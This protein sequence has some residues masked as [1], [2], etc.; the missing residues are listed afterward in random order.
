MHLTPTAHA[1]QSV[2]SREYDN[3]YDEDPDGR[4]P[5]TE[6]KRT[7]LPVRYV[8][9]V[10]LD[11]GSPAASPASG[12]TAAG[13]FASD[14]QVIAFV[15]IPEGVGEGPYKI[16]VLRY[17][18]EE[19]HTS[20]HD[21]LPAQPQ[22]ENGNWQGW[23]SGD[24]EGELPLYVVGAVETSPGEGTDNTFDATG[25]GN[26]FGYLWSEP[27]DDH[28][29]AAVARPKIVLTIGDAIGESG[30]AALDFELEYPRHRIEIVGVDLKRNDRSS[31]IVLWEPDPQGEAACDA[32]ETTGSIK[33]HVLDPE[34]KTAQLR[35]AYRLLNFEDPDPNC[36]M[37]LATEDLHIKTGFKAYD[38]DGVEIASYSGPVISNVAF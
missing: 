13:A 15:D 34:E 6:L 29:P 7:F 16:R 35:V 33:I 27:L 9:R 38:R 23:G 24:P 21:F 12:E 32:S 10:H 31:A 2:T 5:G 1:P 4:K 30:P 14:G 20:S 28:L 36:G 37:R 26:F 19:G 17:L 3:P 8:T 25:W 22:L 11:E 18:R